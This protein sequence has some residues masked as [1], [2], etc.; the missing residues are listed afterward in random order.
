MYNAIS[1]YSKYFHFKYFSGKTELPRMRAGENR[2]LNEKLSCWMK[3][4]ARKKLRYSFIWTMYHF[5]LFVSSICYHAYY[6]RCKK[7]LDSL[8][9]TTKSVKESCSDISRYAADPAKW[10]KPRLIV[11]HPM[12]YRFRWISRVIRIIPRVRQ[13]NWCSQELRPS[14]KEMTEIAAEI[15]RLPKYL[16]HVSWCEAYVA[17][18]GRL[19]HSGGC[20]LCAVKGIC[21]RNVPRA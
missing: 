20:V 5:L 6:R 15:R 3:E 11:I 9:R 13:V 17:L 21:A 16:A 1:R 4:I 7:S 10:I 12:H 8:K 2:K 18:F 19:V 14:R